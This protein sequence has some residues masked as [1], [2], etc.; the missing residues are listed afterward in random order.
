MGVYNFSLDE[1]KLK[2]KM[3]ALDQEEQN[4]FL[5]LAAALGK[6]TE[7][8]FGQLQKEINDKNYSCRTFPIVT[9][10]CKNGNNDGFY[11]IIPKE[12]SDNNIV[13]LNLPVNELQSAYDYEIDGRKIRL[14]RTN[15]FVLK[16]S[17]I[18]SMFSIYNI[19][20]PTVFSPYARRAYKVLESD[21][22]G[23][24]VPVDL[25]KNKI[26]FE[27][28]QIIYAELCWNV[29][30]IPDSKLRR[31]NVIV[32]NIEY[33]RFQNCGQNS[34]ICP[35][36]Y[37][38]SFV[39]TK[40]SSENSIDILKEAYDNSQQKVNKITIIP[41]DAETPERFSSLF[42]RND[43]PYLQ[44][45]NNYADISIAVNKFYPNPEE[46]KGV[47]GFTANSESVKDYSS[48][49]RYF[50]TDDFSEMCRK[51]KKFCYLRFADSNKDIFFEDRVNFFISFI[52][53]FYPNFYW[54]GVK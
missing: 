27:N 1:K 8:M 48:G 13:F 3:T 25:S 38:E 51:N 33:Y 44:K 30:I 54:V 53:Y 9:V 35:D 6:N 29:E 43:V 19:Q 40:T 10:L 2:D 37:Y 39:P 21:K 47:A 41:V 24:Y 15:S 12:E 23:D 16:E 36:K 7:E 5:A 34:F 45:L 18:S 14:E 42:N 20:Q 49:Y 11:P 22:N 31:K 50:Y 4:F 52:R 28:E 17:L 46:F 26:N 32:N